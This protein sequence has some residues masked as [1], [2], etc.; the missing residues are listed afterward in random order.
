MKQKTGQR[1]DSSP[2]QPSNGM[3][4]DALLYTYHGDDVH[5]HTVD[6][7]AHVNVYAHNTV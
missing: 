5:I 6:M 2:T 7:V 3:K 1:Q 4:H